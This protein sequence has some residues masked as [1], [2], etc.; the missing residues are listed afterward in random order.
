MSFTVNFVEKFPDVNIFEEKDVV[1]VYTDIGLMFHYYGDS[2]EKLGVYL[3][4][5]IL[6]TNFSFLQ[7]KLKDKYI[8]E[9]HGKRMSESESFRKFVIHKLN[10]VRETGQLLQDFYTLH[11]SKKRRLQETP[12]IVGMD[13]L[14]WKKDEELS[15]FL[16]GSVRTE[17][18]S[19]REEFEKLPNIGTL[20]NWRTYEWEV[21]DIYLDD[22]A[23]FCY[24][25]RVLPDGKIQPTSVECSKIYIN[26]LGTQT[27]TEDVHTTLADW[28][29]MLRLPE[30][31]GTV[32]GS[33]GINTVLN[34]LQTS[35]QEAFPLMLPALTDVT[36]LNWLFN[37]FLETVLGG[38]FEAQTI[39][40]LAVFASSVWASNS[41]YKYFFSVDGPPYVHVTPTTK[42]S[43][44]GL[45]QY[46]NAIDGTPL[47]NSTTV[48][49]LQSM[50]NVTT[51]I[52]SGGAAFISRKTKEGADFVYKI[53][54]GV[55][56]VGGIG[57]ALKLL[58]D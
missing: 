9:W 58:S 8:E 55:L 25:T 35:V 42:Y 33:I 7:A 50:A 41:V 46:L 15:A 2:R 52:L 17:L 36:Y 49:L 12:E 19:F 20:V 37:F 3:I 57:I 28:F 10:E 11:P 6:H 54:Q 18:L 16:E 56:I 45:R 40:A 14:D 48:S 43:K 23:F 53:F 31:V 13:L 24:L 5:G 21:E 29:G 4:D 26:V 30:I 39:F 22:G 38:N 27:V 1:E 51:Q 34:H 47:T 44:P 32:T